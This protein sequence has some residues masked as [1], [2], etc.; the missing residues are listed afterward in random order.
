ML[1]L[2]RASIEFLDI[3]VDAYV[4]L[5]GISNDSIK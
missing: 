5:H 3:Y 2:L 4:Y 1:A